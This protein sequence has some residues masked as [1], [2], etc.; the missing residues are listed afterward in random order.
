MEPRNRNVWIIVVVVLIVLCCIILAVAAALAAAFGV[1]SVDW[2]RVGAEEHES[3]EQTFKLGRAP[4][5]E[6]DNFS[7]SVSVRAGEGDTIHV[8]GTKR[9]SSRRNLDQIQVEMSEQESGLVIRTR[10]PVSFGSASVE[11]EITAPAGTRLDLHVGSGSIDVRGLDGGVVV[12]SGSGSLTLVDL[13][14][15]LD[16]HSGSGSIDIDRVTG[17]VRA[18]TGSGGIEA[19]YVTGEIDAHTGSGRIEVR[20]GMG[21][22]RLDTGSGSI[23]YEGTPTGDCRFTTGSGGIT[24]LL[25][26]DLNMVVDLQTGSGDIDLGFDVDGRVTKRSVKGTIGSGDRGEIYAHTGSGGINLYRP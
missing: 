24:L 2:G 22:A 8:I 1:W 12:D 10:K 19:Q 6:I 3:I 20:G 5:L 25:P 21:Q 13:G 9:A 16:A 18:D 14:G 11:W 17:N 4:I 26:A 7:G 15:G 23:E